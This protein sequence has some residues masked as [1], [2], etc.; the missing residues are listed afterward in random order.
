M[1]SSLKVQCMKQ[2][3]AGLLWVGLEYTHRVPHSMSAA[4]KYVTPLRAP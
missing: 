3:R 1:K 2:I 4:L